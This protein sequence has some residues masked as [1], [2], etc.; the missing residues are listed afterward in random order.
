MSCVL[1]IEPF[2]YRGCEGMRL[3]DIAS[4]WR[5]A[6]GLSLPW[7]H[8]IRCIFSGQAGTALYTMAMLKAYQVILSK[9]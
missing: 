7:D 9:I 3:Y 4:V 6:R 5:D 1:D 2:Y 8:I